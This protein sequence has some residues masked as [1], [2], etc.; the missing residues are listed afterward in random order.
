[1]LTAFFWGFA[2]LAVASALLCVTRRSPVASA[3]WL[4]LT[5][6]ALAGI[7]V[8][9]D[10]QFIAAIQILVY[11]G[12]IMVLF[13]FVIM[14]LNLGR[15]AVPDMRGWLGRGIA[16]L[17]AAVLLLQLGVVPEHRRVDEDVAVPLESR[18][19]P[20]RDVGVQG[21]HAGKRI[22]GENQRIAA[23]PEG[24]LKAGQRG[25]LA[26]ALE[27]FQCLDV[28]I[29]GGFIEYQDPW[30]DGENRRECCRTPLS[31]RSRSKC[32][33]RRP[34]A[35]QRSGSNAPAGRP[36]HSPART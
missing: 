26:H 19:V 8:L 14:L 3:L 28:E 12:A 16:V 31:T 22:I 13:L 35:C 20:V 10:A 5:M 25:H 9:L 18:P 24:L 15:D 6:F 34:L 29:I 11:A 36:S 23:A 1:M 27:D 33:G 21:V 7:Y 2:G 17:F 30:L 32:H 4:V